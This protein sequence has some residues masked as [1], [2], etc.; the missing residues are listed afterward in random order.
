MIT[1]AGDVSGGLWTAVSSILQGSKF[2]RA[3][4]RLLFVHFWSCFQF[5]LSDTI[6]FAW[7][8][9][10]FT[11]SWHIGL[12]T[13][14]IECSDEQHLKEKLVLLKSEIMLFLSSRLSDRQSL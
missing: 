12:F 11:Y 14:L 8:V 3:K 4:T 5:S 10:R 9:A 6:F 1:K 2:L 7:L 13:V